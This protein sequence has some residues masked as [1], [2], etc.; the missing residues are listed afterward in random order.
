L[1]K[2]I[3]LLYFLIPAFL[4]AQDATVKNLQ[5]EAG[6]TITKDPNDTIPKIWKTGGLIS[7]N[8]SQ[9][10]LSNWAG[11]G[12]KFSLSVNTFINLH[13]FYKKDKNSWDNNLDFNLGYLKATS[14]GTRKSDDRFDITSKYGYAL[15]SKWNI[16]F[17]ADLKSQLF[18]G[19]AYPDANTKIYTS[20]FFAPAYLLLSPGFDYHPVSNFSIFISPVTAR[21]VFVKDTALSTLYGVEAGKK[22]DF[23]FGAYVSFNYKANFTKT[24]TYNGRI[25]LFSNYKHNPQDVDFYMTN[26]FAVKISNALA[27][28]YSLTLIYDDDV[29]QFGANEDA[30]ALQ[31]QSLFGA[32]L[33]LKL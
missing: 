17:L 29:R 27:V 11:G 10:S 28:T 30:P 24:L 16:G 7:L 2:L 15:N 13:A 4:I 22:S 12:D 32:G 14:L 21:W 26:L 31:L 19:Y 1:K 25:D 18:K 8:L 33:L 3:T 9:G 20:N 6:K 5:T 23:Q